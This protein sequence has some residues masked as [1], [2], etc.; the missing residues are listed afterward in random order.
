M[1]LLQ[2]GSSLSGCH[3]VRAAAPGGEPYLMAFE[4]AGRQYSCPLFSFQ[5]RTESFVPIPDPVLGV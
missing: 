1:D 4:F 5:P 2:P 3:I